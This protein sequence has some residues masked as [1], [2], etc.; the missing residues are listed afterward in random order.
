MDAPSKAPERAAHRALLRR[1]G[2]ER[3]GPSS[4]RRTIVDVIRGAPTA[5]RSEQITAV[6]HPSA[7]R[8]VDHHF[9]AKRMVPDHHSSSR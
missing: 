1:V 3:R 6:A 2:R 9:A 8:G 4:T 5:R 7:Q